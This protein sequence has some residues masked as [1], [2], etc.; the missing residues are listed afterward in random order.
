METLYETFF[1][2]STIFIASFIGSGI[3]GNIS[4]T[5]LASVSTLGIAS[6]IGSGINGNYRDMGFGRTFEKDRFFYRKWN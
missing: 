3:N 5:C 2:A 1:P 6:F 4:K